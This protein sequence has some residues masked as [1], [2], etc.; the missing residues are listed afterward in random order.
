MKK[1][2]L[3][4]LCLVL[5]LGL[6]ACDTAQ[7]PEDNTT[8]PPINVDYVY[9]MTTYEHFAWIFDENPDI[10]WEDNGTYT[11]GLKGL[12][13][14]VVVK[15]D[16]LTVAAVTAFGRTQEVNLSPFQG[17]VNAAIEACD[18]AV[19]IRDCED[20][21]CTSWILTKDTVFT[22]RPN[23]DVSTSVHVDDN[24]V[25]C[26]R[27]FWGEYDTS[28]N[29]WDTAPLDLCTDRA[30]FLEERGTITLANG[31][32]SLIKKSTKVL[33]DEYDVD[34]LFAEAKQ[35]GMYEAYDTVDELFAANKNKAE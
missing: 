13:T 3:W 21:S 2:G 6:T 28:F 1:V 24:G 4:L 16:G 29:Q 30:H 35:G 22:Y 19:V 10:P 23:G 17:E 27:T 7:S 12:G 34:A 33:S 15:M 18:G 14:D 32:A 25:L 8:N 26:Y 20:Y 9:D 31:Q 11:I 5:L